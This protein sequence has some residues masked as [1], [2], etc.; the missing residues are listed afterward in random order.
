MAEKQQFKT[1]GTITIGTGHKTAYQFCQ[2]IEKGGGK[3]SHWANGLMESKE[4]I[5]GVISTPKKL[6]LCKATTEELLGK[7][8]TLSEIHAAIIR[9]GGELL[10][11]EAGPQL[12]SQYLKQPT[13]EELNLV[14]KSIN[15]LFEAD[16]SIFYI[17]NIADRLWLDARYG[18]PSYVWN[19]DFRWVFALP[20][21]F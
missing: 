7:A 14:M 6:K 13:G 12:R 20:Q 3:V 4:F 8:G 10:P 19:V 17:R 11:T 9:M 16:L 15:G 18:R 21:N 1:W 5:N 2:V